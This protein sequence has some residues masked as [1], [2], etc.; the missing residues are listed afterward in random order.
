VATIVH[1]TQLGAN[2]KLWCTP[3]SLGLDDG[4]ALG[5]WRDQSGAD[6]DLGQ[7][8]AG[9]RP[10][11]KVDQAAGHPALLFDGVDDLMDSGGNATSTILG[12]SAGFVIVVYKPVTITPA[13]NSIIFQNAGNTVALSIF[14]NGAQRA[15]NVSGGTPTTQDLPIPAAGQVYV[16]VWQHGSALRSALDKPRPRDL[17]GP[18]TTGASDGLSGAFQVG[19]AANIYIFEV[20]AGNKDLSTEER[21]GLVAYCLSRYGKRPNPTAQARGVASRRL[22]YVGRPRLRAEGAVPLSFLGLQLG[23]KLRVSDPSMPDATG[24]GA[25]IDR[26]YQ[27]VM[28]VVRRSQSPSNLGEGLRLGLADVRDVAH[29]YRETTQPLRIADIRR[30][31]VAVSGLGMPRLFQRDSKAWALD[32]GSGLYVEVPVALEKIDAGGL[33]MEALST[34]LLTRSSFKSGTTGLTANGA[35]V[36]GSALA[37]DAAPPK[38]FFSELVTANCGKLTAGTPDTTDLYW[39]WG[40]ASV[41]AGLTHRLSIAHYDH[42][43]TSSALNWRLQ[44]AIDSWYWNDASGAWQSGSI[45]NALSSPGLDVVAREKSKRIPVGG[46]NTTWTLHIGYPAGG[47]DG[48][49]GYICHVQIDETPWMSSPI[50]TDAST[51]TRGAED[52]WIP[53]G[54]TNRL[55]FRN[56]GGGVIVSFTPQWDPADQ[57]AFQAGAFPPHLF[58]ANFTTD[59]QYYRLYFDAAAGALKWYFETSTNGSGGGNM[60]RAEHTTQ[61]VAG[62]EMKLGVRFVSMSE[63]EVG[64][65]AGSLSIFVNGVKGADAVRVANPAHTTSAKL[66][67]GVGRNLPACGVVT[68]FRVVDHSPSDAEMVAMTTV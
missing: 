10:L 61:P 20:I 25:T 13:A 22:V 55:V 40:A 42:T 56:D 33:L 44:R 52:L 3:A 14:T 49:V 30:E 5:S 12:A 58:E 50:V 26:T 66:Q 36:N 37:A 1:P 38:R 15:R 17:A 64:Y 2:L 11:V 45:W 18:S 60:R 47:T 63:A 4:T 21:C 48:R 28:R 27:T 65:A 54:D 35:G 9:L 31:G 53:N 62:T 67:M 68:G 6:R 29:R 46:S 34:N 41:I 19:P 39:A 24:Q 23:D 7:A 16:G 51:V 57:T 59:Q 8:T 32:P 43:A